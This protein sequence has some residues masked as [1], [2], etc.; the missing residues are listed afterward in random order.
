MTEVGAIKQFNVSTTTS[1]NELLIEDLAPFTTYTC[2]VLAFTAVGNGP[3]SQF[4]DITTLED[5]EL[6]S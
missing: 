2:T 3:V 6:R 4:M 1:D 5:G